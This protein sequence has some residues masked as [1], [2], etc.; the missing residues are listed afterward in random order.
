MKVELEKLKTVEVALFSENKKKVYRD[1][2]SHTA[3]YNLLVNR[4]IS[5]QKTGTS[6]RLFATHPK[7]PFVRVTVSDGD[8]VANHVFYFIRIQ[9]MD[10]PFHV[11]AWNDEIIREGS[12]KDVLK[13]I[14][15]NLEDDEIDYVYEEII[16]RY[17]PAYLSRERRSLLKRVKAK[18]M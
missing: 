1:A 16:K 12:L 17:T 2:L 11:F 18:P 15:H 14:L 4:R 3:F 9:H 13:C 6:I 8:V 5:A 10:L 7:K